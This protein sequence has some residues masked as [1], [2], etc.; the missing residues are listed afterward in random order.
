MSKSHVIGFYGHT[1]AS[2]IKSTG[3]A[4]YSC[5]SN[6][7]RCSFVIGGRTFCSTE[8]YLHWNKARLFNDRRVAKLI[9]AEVSK[10]DLDATA[11]VWMSKMKEVKA[12]GRKVKGFEVKLWSELCFDIMLEGLYAKFSK[13]K[14]LRKILLGTGHDTLAEASFR[15]KIWG[16]GLATNNADIQ[17]P[18]KWKGQNLLG[19]ALMKTRKRLRAEEETAK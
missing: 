11:G 4:K 17:N 12:L 7:S 19:Q 8:Q 15:D 3:D 10:D 13:K 9:M 5:L 2:S 18:E 14:K 6:F 16:I 1:D